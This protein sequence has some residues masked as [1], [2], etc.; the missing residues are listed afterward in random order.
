V[1]RQVPIDVLQCQTCGVA[2]LEE[3]WFPPLVAMVPGRCMN[4]GDKR[5]FDNCVN[6]GLTRE[7]DAQ[8]H[9]ELRFMIAPDQNLL[10]AA[11]TAVRVGRNLIALKLATA[12]ASLNE[13]NQGDIARALR[14]W[15]LGRLSDPALALEDARAWV[16]NIPDPSAM[17]WATYGQQ[18]QAEFPGAAAEAYDKALKKD[19][20]QH[21]LRA[22]RA[23]LLMLLHREGQAYDEVCRVLEMQLDESTLNLALAT[24]ERLVDLFENEKR[25]DEIDRLID[26]AGDNVEKSAVLLAHRSRLYALAGDTA[27]AKVDL[28]KARKINP[29]LPVYERVERAM[30]GGRTSWW[31]W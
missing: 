22:R 9:D 18:L 26:R 14:I 6:C 21:Q 15:L 3:D 2:I 17:A 4:C 8:V 25:D 10:E 13:D 7:E 19:R 5:D 27:S 23:H 11:R 12:A 16:E 24:A 20:S 31:R 28:K 30:K 29:E 1:R